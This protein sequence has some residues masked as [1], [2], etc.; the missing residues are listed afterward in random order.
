[1]YDASKGFVGQ[2][3]AAAGIP[4]AEQHQVSGDPSGSLRRATSVLFEVLADHNVNPEKAQERLD[5][6]ASNRMALAG[7]LESDKA[8]LDAHLHHFTP[9]SILQELLGDMFVHPR[10]LRFDKLLGEGAFATVHL[11]RRAAGKPVAVK[12]LKPQ[13][14]QEPHDLKDFLMEVNVMRKLTHSNIVAILGIGASDLSSLDGMRGSMYVLM[15][16]MSGGTLKILVIRQMMST[17]PLYAYTDALHWL[18]QIASAMNYLHNVCRPMIIHRDLKLENMLLTDGPMSERVCKLADFGLHKRARL[19]NLTGQLTTPL[20]FNRGSALDDKS[21]YGGGFFYNNPSVHKGGANIPNMTRK[22]AGSASN[23]SIHARKS[24]NAPLTPAAAAATAQNGAT[25]CTSLAVTAS[26]PP[27]KSQQDNPPNGEYNPPKP[28]YSKESLGAPASPADFGRSTLTLPNTVNISQTGMQ[29]VSPTSSNNPTNHSGNMYPSNNP[30][31]HGAAAS[32]N[33]SAHAGTGMKKVAS[34]RSMVA[35]A[36]AAPPTG[37]FPAGPRSQDASLHDGRS[38]LSPNPS[39]HG[40]QHGGN[41]AFAALAAVGH[42]PEPAQAP[43]LSVDDDKPL[44][45]SLIALTSDP[46]TFHRLGTFSTEA[47]V[48]NTESNSHESL[49]P[50]WATLLKD[51]AQRA[52]LESLQSFLPDSAGQ[53]EGSAAENESVHRKMMALMALDR[54]GKPS[55][56]LQPSHST[57]TALPSAAPSP[58]YGRASAA[59][60]PAGGAGGMKPIPEDNIR[61][62]IDVPSEARPLLQPDAAED[63]PNL[64]TIGEAPSAGPGSKGKGQNKS[65]KGGTAGLKGMHVNA[66]FADATQQVGSLM[67]MSPELVRGHQYNEK[68]DV[69]SFGIMMFELFNGRLLAMRPEFMT[70]GEEAVEEYVKGR[71]NGARDPVPDTWPEEVRQLV[72][73]CWHQDPNLRP[74]FGTVYRRLKALQVSGVLEEWDEAVKNSSA[75]SSCCT[76][77]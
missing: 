34:L 35:A 74:D 56:R 73:S 68:V 24:M 21:Y 17:K 47:K 52:N 37:Q 64:P 4:V 38:A 51:P 27:R 67:Y 36:A 6:A 18:M 8:A 65:V 30:S 76:V 12:Q 31:E 5:K 63:K 3:N 69:F 20:D 15:E 26:S 28:I 19:N 66:Q 14:L 22:S 29:K 50:G 71:S 33:P 11:A 44:S 46:E 42:Q 13:V 57:P 55:N 39:M 59:A 32:N 60:D 54:Q 2:V 25:P 62:S 48:Q 9:E 58:A 16:A 23:P 40:G 53:Q 41:A 43:V 7:E 49:P 1:M 45:S 10:S 70:G 75:S 61:H 72:H 77:S